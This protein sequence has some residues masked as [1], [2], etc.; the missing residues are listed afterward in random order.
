VNGFCHRTCNTKPFFLLNPFRHRGRRSFVPPARAVKGEPS[1]FM[2]HPLRPQRGTHNASR[3]G[4]EKCS[5]I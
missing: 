1:E 5:A 2:E 3:N 4:M